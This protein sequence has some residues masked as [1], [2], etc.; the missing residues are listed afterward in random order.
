[1]R[2]DVSL[3]DKNVV[4]VI[5]P[6]NFND[7]ELLGPKRILEEEGFQVTI[8]STSAGE[9]LGMKGTVVKSSLTLEQI[10]PDEFDAIIAIGGRGAM[11]YLQ[12][13]EHLIKLFKS[14]HSM[15]KIVS[16]IGRARHALHKAGL[17]GTNFSWGPEVEINGNIIAARPPSTTPG[18][19]SKRYG[20]LLVQ[21]LRHKNRSCVT[22][23]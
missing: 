18:W 3:S 2:C 21:H 5:A 4:F 10:D 14:F 7:S 9:C 13:N 8:V 22:L 23:G 16:A 17:F 6:E 20:H 15:G 11:N 19:D 12:D 1:M